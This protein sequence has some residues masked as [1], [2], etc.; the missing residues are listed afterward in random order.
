MEPNEFRRFLNSAIQNSR[1]VT[2]LLQK[3]KAK[4]P[5]FDQW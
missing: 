2:F 4:W 1:G 5:D 3:R